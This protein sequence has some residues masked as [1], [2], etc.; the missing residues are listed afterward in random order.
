MRQCCGRWIVCACILVPALASSDV[1]LDAPSLCE[2]SAALA[3]PWDPGLALVADNEIDEQLFAFSRNGERLVFRRALALPKE[4]RPHDTEALAAVGSQLL[5]VGSHGPSRSGE[6]KPKRA[7]LA[8]YAPDGAGGV[9]RLVRALDDAARLDAARRNVA[10]CLAGLFV[11]PAPRQ[12]EA[13][14]RALVAGAPQVEGATTFA[15][16]GGATPRVWLGLRT[17]LVE[18]RAVLLRLAPELE[19][20]RFDAIALADLDGRGV[21]E[22]AISGDMLAGIAGHPADGGPPPRIWLSPAAELR[23]GATLAPRWGETLPQGA[24]GLLPIPGGA[25]VV[26]D[27]NRAGGGASAC[28]GP[29]RQL[30]VSWPSEATERR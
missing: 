24:E 30:F 7:R 19:E 9:L 8:L 2:A 11:S 27:V 15:G 14:C 29:A 21:R 25:I 12:A 10:A 16:P 5:V 3:A 26:T 28:A 18:G 6:P 1:P 4:G 13:V 17:P 20:L 23:D 22:L